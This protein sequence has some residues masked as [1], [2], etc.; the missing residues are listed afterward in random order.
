[1]FPKWK[2]WNLEYTFKGILK[3]KV[4]KALR[5]GLLIGAIVG[6]YQLKKSGESFVDLPGLWG[7]YFKDRLTEVLNSVTA[8][9]S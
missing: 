6:A 9:I 1:M 7:R 3:K 2:D 4:G 5:Y 8:R